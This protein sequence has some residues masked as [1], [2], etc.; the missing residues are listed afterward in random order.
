MRRLMTILALL[1]LASCGREAAVPTS[2]DG[3]LNAAD[4][5]RLR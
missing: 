2:E 5:N 1:T 4:A 3:E